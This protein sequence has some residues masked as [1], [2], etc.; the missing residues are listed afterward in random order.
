[1][2]VERLNG[3]NNMA[4]KILSILGL[5]FALVGIVLGGNL[6]LVLVGCVILGLG[7]II[8]DKEESTTSS[9][10][11][12]IKEFFEDVQFNPNTHMLNVSDTNIPLPK[13]DYCSGSGY[14]Q[15]RYKGLDVEFCTLKLTD[16][17]EVLRDETGLWEKNENTVYTG[18][19]LLCKLDQ[20]FN[21]WLTI[22]PRSLLDKQSSKTVN[23]TFDKKFN[24]RCGDEKLVLE[25]LNSKRLERIMALSNRKFSINLNEDGRLYI[26][27]H[28]RHGFNSESL[29]WFVDMIDVF[30]E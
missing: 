6:V 1:M 5:L 14:V 3:K 20:R 4:K 19:W 10:D 7:Q 26:T 17:T 30:R 9:M 11:V 27:V 12:I 16:V 22:Y 28:D 29:Q 24:L 18:E 23:E 21:T 8:K 2:E 13:H 15:A 25:I